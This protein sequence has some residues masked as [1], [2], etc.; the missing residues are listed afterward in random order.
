MNQEKKR[1]YFDKPCKKIFKW[2]G[3][4]THK[5]KQIG[6]RNLSFEGNKFVIRKRKSNHQKTRLRNSEKSDSQ[7][8]R[9]TEA[10]I[11]DHEISESRSKSMLTEEDKLTSKVNKTRLYWESSSLFIPNVFK[12]LSFDTNEKIVSEY[13]DLSKKEVLAQNGMSK[14]K[15]ECFDSIVVSQKTK[16]KKLTSKNSNN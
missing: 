16:N 3:S 11:S 14:D 6:L 5:N 4:K 13:Q 12:F 7:R 9:S 10:S 1:L 2:T 8:G 15:R